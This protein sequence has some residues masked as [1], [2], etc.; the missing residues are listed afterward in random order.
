MKREDATREVIEAK[1]RLG[2]KWETI[3]AAVGRHKVW[4]TAALLGQ[5]AMSA[6]E[7]SNAAAVLEL[8]KDV[9]VALQQIPTRGSEQRIPADPTMYRF[10]EM[11]QVYAPAMKEIVHELCGDGIVSAIDF[12]MDIVK[13]ED[14]AGDRVVVTLDGK[15]LPY[16]K[17]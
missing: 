8:S 16:K 17:F 14:P 7:A 2:L 1:I 5:H 11:L 12:K 13:K 9:Q 15:F 4:T 6:E 10:Y 3:A